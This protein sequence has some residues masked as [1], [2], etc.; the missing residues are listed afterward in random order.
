MRKLLLRVMVFGLA[1]GISGCVGLEP[2]E[3]REALYG[4]ASP[5][6]HKSYAANMVAPGDTWKVYLNASDA[7]GDMKNIV[8][9]VD[10]PG[11]GTYPASLTRLGEGRQKELSGFVYLNTQGYESLNFVTLNLTLQV[12]DMA[13][14]FSQPAIFPLLITAAGPQEPPP[15]GDFQEVN[16]GPIL[17]RLRTLQEDMGG[18]FNRGIFFR[19]GVR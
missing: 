11:V 2:L 7:D 16:L 10:Q 4:K 1:A 14:H 13:G 5:V 9:T 3:K 19:E 17:I 15:P 12:Q 6:I 18:P 8:C